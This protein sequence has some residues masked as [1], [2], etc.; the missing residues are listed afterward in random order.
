MLNPDVPV[1]GRS[2]G[3]YLAPGFRLTH[4]WKLRGYQAVLLYTR[5]N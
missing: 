3:A 4:E 2:P 1:P 5:T